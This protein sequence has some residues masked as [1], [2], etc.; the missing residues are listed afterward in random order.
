MTKENVEK[1]YTDEKTGK[2]RKGNPGGGRPKGSLSVVAELKKQLE[3]C[4]EGDK[5]TYL[6]ILVKKVLKKGIVDG[7]V[8]MIKDIINRVDGMP[9]QTMEQ[10]ITVKEYQWGEYEDEEIKE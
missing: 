1:R 10:E 4:P 8:T 2:F 7:D 5:R 3:E 6:E 9:K